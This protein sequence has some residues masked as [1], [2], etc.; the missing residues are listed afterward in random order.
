M[1]RIILAL[2]ALYKRCL[3]PLFGARCRFHPSCSDYARVAVAR[4]G[5]LRGGTLALWRIGR[6][7]PLCR[8]GFDPVPE[9]FT[10][11]RCAHKEHQA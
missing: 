2:L 5:A 9:T 1:T 7:Q 8:G 11:R 3:S 4:F 6:C 10:M